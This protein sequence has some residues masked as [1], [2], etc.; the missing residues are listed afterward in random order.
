[1]RNRVKELRNVP[2]GA[3]RA[4]EKNWRLHPDGQRE[5]LRG[6]LDRVGMVGALIARE[7]PD[8]L[9]LLDGHLRAELADNE[10]VP[11]V[12]VDLDD[13]EAE[14]VLTTFDP[15][16]DMALVDDAKLSA[17][18]AD[19]GDDDNAEFRRMFTD[20]ARKVKE[21]DIADPD[22]KRVVEGME[23]QPHEHYDYLVVLATTVQEWNVL[24]DKLSLPK[25]NLPRGKLGT[26]RAMRASKLLEIINNAA[27]QDR[28]AEPKASSEH[29]VDPQPA[30]D[31]NGV[32]RRARN[33]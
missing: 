19:L 13:R 5:A 32:R 7:T 3:L 33:R 28:R 23:L 1:M 4:N 26:S 22:S 21:E 29:A 17:L 31:S 8:G 27:V 9:E 16:G 6:I 10:E 18:L 30:A 20:L 14:F 2:A 24:C 15:V 25:I 12:I 11:V